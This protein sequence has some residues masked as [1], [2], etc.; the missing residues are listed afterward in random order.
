MDVAIWL[1]IEFAGWFVAGAVAAVLALECDAIG[2]R[3]APALVLSGPLG[4][5]LLLRR[6]RSAR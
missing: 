6:A 3:W 1:L 4:L 5:L 2:L